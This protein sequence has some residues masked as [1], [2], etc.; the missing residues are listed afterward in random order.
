MLGMMSR[1]TWIS[2]TLFALTANL[3]LYSGVL[4]AG[5]LWRRASIASQRRWRS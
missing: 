4:I 2:A 3:K 1:R 5:F